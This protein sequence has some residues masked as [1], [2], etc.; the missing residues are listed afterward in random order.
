MIPGAAI[1]IITHLL[2]KVLLPTFQ[3]SAFDISAKCLLESSI[4]GAICA[5]YGFA[6]IADA[7]PLITNVC[8]L[9]KFRNFYFIH[10]G[11][12]VN[13]THFYANVLK[14]TDQ[15]QFVRAPWSVHSIRSL[16][17]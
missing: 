16:G 11:A 13:L 3:I 6:S 8:R 4:D 9:S 1:I 12:T 14:H 7:G 15:V 2:V 5:A 17:I 10:S